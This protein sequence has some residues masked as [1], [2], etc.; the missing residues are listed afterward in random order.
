M[1]RTKRIN[2]FTNKTFVYSIYLL[3][4]LNIGSFIYKHDYESMFLFSIMCIVTFLFTKNFIIVLFVSLM[5]VNTLILLRMLNDKV[6][7]GAVGNMDANKYSSI[8]EMKSSMNDVIKKLENEKNVDVLLEMMKEFVEYNKSNLKDEDTLKEEKDI[9]EKLNN[10]ILG[11]EQTDEE[12]DFIKENSISKFIHESELKKKKSDVVEDEESVQDVNEDDTSETYES[13]GSEVDKEK[14][15]KFLEE[16]IKKEKDIDS[17]STKTEK[18]GFKNQNNNGIGKNDLTEYPNDP[19]ELIQKMK[20]LNPSLKKSMNVL[21]NLNM[22]ELN[23]MVNS[24]DSVLEK[25]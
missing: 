21:K 6:F 8:I 12:N 23:N 15:K 19:N 17:S 16:I 2:M 18:S 3:T 7:E 24:L 14:T 10:Y 11:N 22:N 25:L 1:A 9:L 4:A 20:N 13:E 5:F